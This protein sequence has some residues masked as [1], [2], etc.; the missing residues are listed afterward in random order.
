M[1]NNKISIIS[2]KLDKRLPI[3]ENRLIYKNYCI[4]FKSLIRPT[5]T[6]KLKK[7]SNKVMKIVKAESR[8]ILILGAGSG[9]GNE[10]LKLFLNNKKINIIGTYY[11]NKI[12]LSEKNLIKIKFDIEN[13]QS[14]R[15][16]ENLVKK[17]APMTIYYLPTPKIRNLVPSNETKNVYRKYYINWPCKILEIIKNLDCNFFYPSTTFIND[18]S[19]SSYSKIK[20]IAEKKLIKFKN[21]KINI[22]IL[23]IPPVN[24]KQNLLLVNKIFPNFTDLIENNENVRN[25]V[26]FKDR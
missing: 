22:N 8:N 20:K 10:L 4:N 11:K 3:I 23:R 12:F 15:F 25:S 2:R 24:T 9:I 14:I 19:L 16:I 18:N 26:F 21:S 6:I 7:V 17:Y 13:K 5:H 1:L